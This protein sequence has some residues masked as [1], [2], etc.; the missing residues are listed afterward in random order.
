MYQNWNKRKLGKRR[1]ADVCN[2]F[3][4]FY[5]RFVASFLTFCYAVLSFLSRCCIT[6]PTVFSRLPRFYVRR[7]PFFPG[8]AGVAVGMIQVA[9]HHVYEELISHMCS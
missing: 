5:V 9:K 1:L 6:S 8:Y 7:L 3:P 4:S 2:Q